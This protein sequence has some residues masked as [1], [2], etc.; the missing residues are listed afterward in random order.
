MIHADEEV[1][2]ESLQEWAESFVAGLPAP[3]VIKYIR[4][5]SQEPGRQAEAD[6]LRAELRRVC[7]ST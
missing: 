1:T 3:A 2:V 4:F 5:L 6:A 7:E